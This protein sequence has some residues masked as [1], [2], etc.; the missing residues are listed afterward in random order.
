MANTVQADRTDVKQEN[1]LG[2][3]KHNLVQML[4]EIIGNRGYE[5]YICKS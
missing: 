1:D 4:L 2:A 5:A 3:L